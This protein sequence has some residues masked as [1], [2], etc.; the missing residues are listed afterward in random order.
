MDNTLFVCFYLLCNLLSSYI[1]YKFFKIFFNNRICNNE[2][3]FLVYIM[4]FFSTSIV[5]LT[6]HQPI[7]TL[8]TNLISLFVITLLYESKIMNKIIAVGLVYIISLLAESCIVLIGI[9]Y[10]WRYLEIS[11]MLI[12]RVALLVIVQLLNTNKFLQKDIL[13]PKI[14]WISIIIFPIGS[15]IIFE[16]SSYNLTPSYFL[17]CLLV[18]LLFNILIFYVFDRLN[19][20]YI[21]DLTNKLKLQEK[22]IEAKL[23]YR[24]S[25]TQD[26]C[27]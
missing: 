1:I 24:E 4:Y 21:A 8:I 20:E 7:L 23:F 5:Y 11:C 15:I 19:K 18:L 14:Q 12:S 3:E 16:V 6:Y 2:L 25:L 26:K 17:V 10:H 13:I 27:W 22:T 9:F